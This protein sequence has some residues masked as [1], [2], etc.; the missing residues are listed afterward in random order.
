M[1]EPL[2]AVRDLTVAF[3]G[4]E[5]EATVVDRVSLDVAAGEVLA[6]VGESGSGK[7]VTAAATIGLIR[8]RG[9]RIEGSV[10]YRGSELLGASEDALRRVRGAE[11]AMVFQDPLSSLNPV[12]RVADQI[13]EQI[14][15]HERVGRGAARERAVELLHRVG[16]ARAER[17]ADAYPHEL[18]GG[19]RQRAM[20]AMALSCRPGLLIA[21]EPT[22]ALDVTVQ[23]Q[24][25]DLVRELRDEI[26]AGV[27]LI[28]HD[29]GVVA[30][31]ADRVAVMDA[32]L[33]VEHGAVRE[34][35]AAP[36]HPTTR[37]LLDAVPRI[38]GPLRPRRVAP[39]E[40]VLALDRLEVHFPVRTGV[41]R[42]REVARIRA[43]DGVT[44]TVARGETVALVGESGSGKSTLAR[45]AVRL[46]EPTG[47]RVSF[48]GRDITD[49][50][51]R[52]LR[53]LR[54]ELQIV[55][56]D[57][58]GSLNPRK[59]VCDIVGLPLALH[60]VPKAD[61]RARIERL[62]GRVGLPSEHA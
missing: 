33:I 13:A 30:E 6:L 59:R 15:A 32:G 27:L 35:F 2:L 23:A 49:A 54:S 38:D 52:E 21:D 42:T 60:G 17:R 39:D 7:S 9:V 19:M 8:S 58:Y 48:A 53:S 16:I 44:L 10:R 22:T 46:I 18:S 3:A 28:T 45:A 37:A 26:G 20:I 55:F 4:A 12:Q 14:L 56:Q 31:M 43:V 25:L 24:I 61:R 57:P 47:G 62:L 40:P 51:A 50:S 5:G 34:L 1:S 11:I 29:F 36:G 41:L